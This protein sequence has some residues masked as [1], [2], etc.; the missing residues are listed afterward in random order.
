MAAPEQEWPAP[1]LVDYH[2]SAAQDELWELA[3]RLLA[4]P[5][6]GEAWGWAL[7]R[8][9]IE[10]LSEASRFKASW[11]LSEIFTAWDA[12]IHLYAGTD[13]AKP[14]VLPRGRTGPLRNVATQARALSRALAYHRE[15]DG[16]LF[17]PARSA[18][19]PAN[20]TVRL[21]A[22]LEALAADADNLVE[23]YVRYHPSPRGDVGGSRHPRR[24]AMNR[25]LARAFHDD[26]PLAARDRRMI[27]IIT[28]T[29]L[30]NLLDAPGPVTGRDV[31]EDLR[32]FD[33]ARPHPAFDV[34]WFERLNQ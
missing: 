9:R 15:L 13:Q 24:K 31:K 3:G 25:L 10:P 12:C 17:N 5:A 16:L 26:A 34:T 7:A 11:V 21:A 28:E 27:G 18:G 19:W 1:W 30:G 22:V 23:E 32:G 29:A 33:P 8:A 14:L 4:N 20:P 6:M 2:A